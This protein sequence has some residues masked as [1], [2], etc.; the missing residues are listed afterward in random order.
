MKNP[1]AL[2][3]AIVCTFALLG[4]SNLR[5]AEAT[6]T[7]SATILQPVTITKLDNLDFGKI[8]AGSSPGE[9]TLT[10][11]SQFK[12]GTGLTCLEPEPKV[13]E[14]YQHVV[15]HASL[16]RDGVNDDMDWYCPARA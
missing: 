1:Y 10:A 3:A 13:V 2:R 5:A 16:R 7:A 8:I 15:I 12:C 6:G 14:Q 9:V 11:Q 4:P